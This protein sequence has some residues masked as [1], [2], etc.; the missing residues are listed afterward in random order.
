M[1]VSPS[2]HQSLDSEILCNVDYIHCDGDSPG[3]S[4]CVLLPSKIFLGGWII[5]GLCTILLAGSKSV[6]AKMF[7]I[8]FKKNTTLCQ[9]QNAVDSTKR[10]VKQ[11]RIRLTMLDFWTELCQLTVCTCDQVPF[12]GRNSFE[13]GRCLWSADSDR[14]IGVRGRQPGGCA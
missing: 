1:I 8:K 11:V 9:L 7:E 14:Q 3:P 13:W 5:V 4:P 6:C 12:S 2:V 10:N